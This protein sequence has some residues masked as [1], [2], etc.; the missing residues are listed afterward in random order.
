MPAEQ[1]REAAPVDEKEKRAVLKEFRR[2]PG[3]GPAVAGDLWR[4]GLRSVADLRGRDPQALYDRLCELQGMHVDRCMLYVMRCAVY[5]A[6]NEQHDPELLKWWSWKDGA[7][8]ARPPA[9]SR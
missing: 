4:L 3:V 9:A 1:A 7:S 2:I 8:V 6:S 5:F